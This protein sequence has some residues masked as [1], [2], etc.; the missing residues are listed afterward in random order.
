MIENNCLSELEQF[1]SV[2]LI[3]E[4]IASSC[5]VNRS[6]FTPPFTCGK[7]R[8]KPNIFCKWSQWIRSTRAPITLK[9][10]SADF[11][12]LIVA[13]R[14]SRKSKIQTILKILFC[15]KADRG[16]WLLLNFKLG[17]WTSNY[18]VKV[19]LHAAFWFGLVGGFFGTFFFSPTVPV[20][21]AVSWFLVVWGLFCFFLEF[22]AFVSPVLLRGS[23]AD[24]GSESVDLMDYTDLSLNS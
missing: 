16:L 11:S 19:Y 13:W 8:L 6:V 20:C 9:W 7:Q 5:K 22:T 1:L 2:V 21:I 18:K 14:L 23:L 24:L 17:I 4:F 15:F 10:I 3:S 12:L